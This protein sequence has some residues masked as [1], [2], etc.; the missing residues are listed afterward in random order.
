MRNPD[1]SIQGLNKVTIEVTVS[2]G[3]GVG[4]KSERGGG[5]GQRSEFVR[6][7][8]A[9]RMDG[10]EYASAEGGASSMDAAV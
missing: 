6:R 1:A 2:A 10:S 7:G 8:C 9:E 3:A 5:C 4:F